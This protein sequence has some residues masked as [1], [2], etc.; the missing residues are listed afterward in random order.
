MSH[1]FFCFCKASAI[2]YEACKTNLTFHINSHN[3][4]WTAETSVCVKWPELFIDDAKNTLGT[5][6]KICFYSW[7]MISMSTSLPCYKSLPVYHVAVLWTFFPWMPTKT[8]SYSHGKFTVMHQKPSIGIVL[9]YLCG[10][11]MSQ[12]P[13]F[14][15]KKCMSQCCIISGAQCGLPKL[16]KQNS[17]GVHVQI[18]FLHVICWV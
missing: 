6:T 11:S 16:L 13:L 9:L 2:Q 18:S 3:S 10:S 15:R 8:K 17:P 7:G 12:H 14:Y 5:M 4:S 1:Y